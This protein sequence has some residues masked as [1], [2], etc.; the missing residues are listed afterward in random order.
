MCAGPARKYGLQ[1]KFVRMRELHCLLHYLIYSYA[2]E[3]DLDQEQ[4][5]GRNQ[6]K[7]KR[8]PCR[9]VDP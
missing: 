6:K 9:T 7:S 1:P 4:A 8:H 3:P 5:I 2:G